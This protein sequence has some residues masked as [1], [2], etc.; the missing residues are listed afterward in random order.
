[1]SHKRFL[2]KQLV[3]EKFRDFF[4]KD[5][6]LGKAVALSVFMHVLLALAFASLHSEKVT[7]IRDESKKPLLFEFVKNDDVDITKTKRTN[8]DN[9][10]DGSNQNNPNSR[11]KL[12]KSRGV[13]WSTSKSLVAEKTKVNKKAAMMASLTGLSELRES[14]SFVLH[15]ISTDSLGSFTPIQGTAPDIDFLSD[16]MENGRGW[17]TR[18]GVIIGIGGGGGGNCPPR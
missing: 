12:G 4:S 18:S 2:L 14:F 1:M 5:F 13:R 7:G 6:S 11:E 15:Q 17:G 8:I 10:A 3:L 9:N 16:G